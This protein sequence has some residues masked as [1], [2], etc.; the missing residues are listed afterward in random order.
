MIKEYLKNKGISTYSLAQKTGVS[1]STVNDIVN[2]KTNIENVRLGVAKAL[3]DALE[4]NLDEL[5]E[6]C[7]DAR[8]T[9]SPE[10]GAVCDII[11]KNK[12][13]Y[14]DFTYQGEPVSLRLCK[15]TQRVER[16]VDIIAG[17]EA[18]KYI[19]ARRLKEAKWNTF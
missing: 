14:A 3:S 2:R 6:L 9:V 16:Y 17:W 11:S 15:V 7:S 18:D 8:R 4:I 13:Y 10:Y 12:S 1:Y 19:A 5:I